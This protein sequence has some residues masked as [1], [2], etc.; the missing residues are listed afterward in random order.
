MDFNGQRLWLLSLAVQKN[1]F[2]TYCGA[3]IIVDSNSR[4]FKIFTDTQFQ[5]K[6]LGDS[7]SSLQDER[8]SVC[9]REN[10]LQ[11]MH[12][13]AEDNGYI[14]NKNYKIQQADVQPEWRQY[15]AAA[16]ACFKI[17]W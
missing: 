9:D 1:I 11:S 12:S 4:Q 16:S 10:E 17:Q 3:W 8:I 13:D 15:W 7:P 2:I 6:L 14:M 5:Y